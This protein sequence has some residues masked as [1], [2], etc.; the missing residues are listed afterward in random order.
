MEKLML[1]LLA[2]STLANAQFIE[3]SFPAPSDNIS[4]LGYNGM[5]W[6]LDSLDCAV[7]GVDW[8]TGV[9]YD[10]VPLP[11]LDNPAVGL[12][13]SPDGF[14]FAESGTAVIHSIDFDGNLLSTFDLSDSGV[15]SVSGVD[16]FHW[17][18]SFPYL[19]LIDAADRS[20]YQI[21]LFIGP[22]SLVK[23]FTIEDEIEV[24][25]IGWEYYSLPVACNDG[26]S[27]VR[28]YYDGG[29]LYETLGYGEYQSAVGV[30]STLDDRIYFSDPEMGLIHRYCLNMGEVED[31]SYQA[32]STIVMNPF[33]NPVHNSVSAEI[34]LAE[35]AHIS[36][37]V[38]DIAGRV[39]AEIPESDYCRGTHS[40]PLGE[41]YQ[42]VYFCLMTSGYYKESQRFAVVN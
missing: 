38:I 33:S 19:W 31:G 28:F 11:P 37:Q 34:V 15:Q 26:E 6:A 20:V 17:S 18:P 21:S 24:H 25:D 5:V 27:P 32:V 29:S 39:A 14:W 8:W 2:A 10:T 7:Y 22:Q 16:Y 35:P 40:V 12:G 13:V 30:A 36:F 41:F 9:P 4:G 42:G 1:V 3:V 23:L